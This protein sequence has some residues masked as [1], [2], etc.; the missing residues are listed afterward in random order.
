MTN[1]PTPTLGPNGFLAPLESAILQGVLAD[2][3]AAF[4]GNLN[5][6]Q[7]TPQGQLAVSTAAVI[8]YMNDLYL[9][10]TNGVDPAY[11][12]GRMQD[13][14]AR[15]Y[16]LERQ[17]ALSTTVQ[18][19]CNGLT[20]TIIPTG[21]LAQAIDGNIYQ[22]LEG[23]TIPPGGFLS[24][25]FACVTTGPI[26]CPV[27]SLNRIYQTVPGWDSINNPSEGTLGRNVESRADFEQR[28]AESVAIN[29]VG[30]LPA[31][32]A[33]VLN[34]ADV[35]DAYVAE[36]DTGSTVV[37]GGVTLA[38]HSIYV[39]VNG[40]AQ[41]DVARAIW[42]KKPPGCGYTSTG[43]T[44]TVV[45]TDDNSGYSIPYPTYDVIFDPAQSLPI[46]FAVSIADSVGVPANATDQIRDVIMAAFNGDDGGPRARIGSTIFASRFY[47][48][49]AALGSW[50]QIIAINI[51]SPNGAAAYFTGSIAGTTLTVSAVA[52]G[53]LAVGQ[54]ITALGVIGGSK[55]TAFGTG[56]GGTGTYTVGK[57]QTLSSRSM[58]GTVP[59]LDQLTVPINFAPTLDADNITVTLV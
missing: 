54:T 26:P 12:S 14:I 24:L 30:V 37:I 35:L 31:I 15:I 40:G 28:R 58:Q 7:T 9:A 16:F 36:N 34:V 57:T 44:V 56:S 5:L 20:G 47:A 42:R 3:D 46:L 23:G 33:S 27:D 18:C 6:Q 19:D 29:A 11:A 41:A 2:L 50:A 51:G 1:V 53:T 49:I 52:S 55:I 43:T 48:G 22:C 25:V 17:P 21:A 13:A 32:R 59:L 38:A 39:C 4:G 10:Y 45:V 8:G